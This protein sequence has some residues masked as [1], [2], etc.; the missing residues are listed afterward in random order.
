VRPLT[1]QNAQGTFRSSLWSKGPVVSYSVP[2]VTGP[3]KIGHVGSRN[4]TIFK[5]FATHNFLLQY[6]MA[7]Q[8]S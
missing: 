2:Y 3:A 8:F 5:T 1:W 7:T 4:L 6:G